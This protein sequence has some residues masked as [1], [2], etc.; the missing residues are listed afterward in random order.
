[1]CSRRTKQ[2]FLV[3]EKTITVILDVKGANDP[4]TRGLLPKLRDR[5]S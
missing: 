1:M 3:M 4:T 5:W 2:E